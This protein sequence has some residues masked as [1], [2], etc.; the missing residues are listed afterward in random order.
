MLTQH[1]Q[2]RQSFGKKLIACIA[3]IALQTQALTPAWAALSQ[4]P[5]LASAGNTPKPNVMLTLDTSGSMNF[6][7][8]P[9]ST[10]K[11]NGI[12]LTVTGANTY[13]HHPDDTYE[14]GVN[15]LGFMSADIKNLADESE[16]LKQQI[17]FR[18]PDVNTIYYNPQE[19]Y[20]PWKKAD[21]TS[22]PLAL[23][24]Q[25]FIDPT[26]Q[27]AGIDTAIDLT[28]T[29]EKS[30]EA[31]FWPGIYYLLKPNTPT[32]DTPNTASYKLYNIND[33]LVTS[34][35]KHDARTDCQSIPGFCSPDEELKNFANWFVYYRTRFLL[36]KAALSETF[37]KIENVARL[38]WTTIL[39]AREHGLA[40]RPR[41]ENK[42]APILKPVQPLTTAH[43]T[44]LITTLQ[45]ANFKAGDS[46][47]LRQALDSVGRYFTATN[48]E[49]GPWR[50]D[51]TSVS[52]SGTQSACR[53]S[54]NI[55]TTDGYYNNDFLKDD[56]LVGNFD[57]TSH[58]KQVRSAISTGDNS[59]APTS[60]TTDTYENTLADFALKYWLTDLQ[61]DIADSVKATTGEPADPATWQH[62][63]QL[64]IG[65]GVAGTLNS[66][67]DKPLL[68]SGA[69]TWPNPF[70]SDPAKIDD[71]WHAAEN[72]R[73]KF[74]S[75][76]NASD[77]KK[78]I[79]DAIEN[80][81]PLELNEGGVGLAGNTVESGT[82]K[83]VPRYD[84][85]TWTGDLDAYVLDVQGTASADPIWSASKHIP[86]ASARK[87]FTSNPGGVGGVGSVGVAFTSGTDFQIAPPLPN[88]LINYIRGDASNEGFDSDQYRRRKGKLADFIN[89]SP[90]FVK[91][92]VNQRYGNLAA[93]GTEYASFL[94]AKENRTAVVFL[95]SNGGFLHGFRDTLNTPATDG[96]EIYGYAPRGVLGNLNKLSLQSYG[97]VGGDNEHQFLVDGPVI[98]SDV[99]I[100]KGTTTS[101]RNVLVGAL[102]AGGKGLYA[103][104]VTSLDD[105]QASTGL[106]VNSILWDA[107]LPP[108]TGASAD[109]GRILSA[110]VVGPLLGGGWVALAGN[111]YESDNG[112]AAL[113]AYDMATGSVTSTPTSLT[114]SGNGLGGLTVLRNANQEIV[115]AYAGDLKGNLWRFERKSTATGT[116]WV[117]GYGGTP[118]FTATIGTQIQ[119]ITAAPAVIPHPAGGNMIVFGTG[120]LLEN[121]DKTNLS[122][123][124]SVYGIWDKKPITSDSGTSPTET[125]IPT[126][127]DQWLVQQT[128]TQVPAPAGSKSEI[129]SVFTISSNPQ[130]VAKR[131]WYLV[132]TNLSPAGQ[133]VIYPVQRILDSK[134][135]L[136]SSI[137]P[138]ATAAECE[139][140][141]SSGINIILPGLSGAQRSA[142]TIDIN[143]DGVINALDGNYAGFGTRADGSDSVQ[144]HDPSSSPDMTGDTKDTVV[145]QST[146]D[147]TRA[148]PGCGGD[149]DDGIKRTILDRT[150]KR[151]VNVP[152]PT[153]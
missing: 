49:G 91:G 53:R 134:Y 66:Q 86:D 130:T 95:G 98:E 138:S 46:T 102:G 92:N 50:D 93:G 5:L 94:T 141:T 38:G 16:A 58:A 57:G 33:P 59:Y 106:G 122:D 30:G 136:I 28:K 10:A 117:V 123:V 56:Q 111:G 4:K 8:M 13:V 24:K 113:L 131:G 12:N 124:Q 151:I 129:K 103:L 47:P 120:K 99:Y 68:I 6:R 142:P 150:W 29:L 121:D 15:Y 127:R 17:Y 128:I 135:V 32:N 14:N 51:L 145:I 153:H 107:T 139:T 79:I 54:Y 3:I 88:D 63:T 40:A 140:A 67:T 35:K 104:D 25:A 37:Y 118:V 45:D 114:E 20:T 110:P 144:G 101:W 77:L 64:T 48:A 87:L 152:Q 52:A 148:C 97:L 76:K 109:V 82:R 43:R 36:T 21:G 126:A 96:T 90:V 72:S 41:N 73:G 19:R 119:P 39:Y 27:R 149:D 65:I 85:R 89:S 81:N 71:L 2:A 100:T 23:P 146:K 83:Y 18:S 132:L 143:G 11:V 42:L 75:V 105:T 112:R 70:S 1:Q 22:Y 55:M 34:Y 80:A 69:K 7:H 125:S 31:Y 61:P 147:K 62:L 78:A 44:L 116:T 84:G 137:A 26:K 9:E 60:L 108:G 74:Y 133:R 115:G